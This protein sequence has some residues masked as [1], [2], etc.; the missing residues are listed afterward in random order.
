MSSI[1][2]VSAILAGFV[3]AHA[4][5]SVSDLPE[6]ELLVPLAMVEVSGERHLQ[7]FEAA[8]QEQAIAAG[9]AAMQRVLS[10]GAVWAF[11][12]DGRFSRD[13][14]SV[15]VISVDFWGKGMTEPATVVQEYQPAAHPGG[16]RLLGE[17]LLVIDG[18]AQSPA[19]AR[20][21]LAQIRSGIQSHSKASALWNSR[22]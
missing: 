4:V 1:P 2:E 10:T 19:T 16:F 5:W 22:P 15:D 6:G 8:T 18:V 20:V 7:R 11:A 17:P 21:V 13:G 12:R 9:K 14:R 3:L